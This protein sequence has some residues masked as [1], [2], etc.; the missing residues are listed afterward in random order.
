MEGVEAVCFPCILQAHTSLK[1]AIAKMRLLAKKRRACHTLVPK[2]ESHMILASIVHEPRAGTLLRH[3]LSFLLLGSKAEVVQ[4]CPEHGEATCRSQCAH[5]WW[6]WH[7]SGTSILMEQGDLNFTARLGNFKFDSVIRFEV[8]LWEWRYVAGALGLPGARE[9][10]SEAQWLNSK[11]QFSSCSV[12]GAWRKLSTKL[13]VCL[14]EGLSWQG[15][16]RVRAVLLCVN[17]YVEAWQ[18]IVTHLL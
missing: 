5:W 16:W 12:S 3:P 1:C 4:L 17:W 7:W 14:Q 6:G 10:Q 15:V 2:P 9:Q 18:G 11:L 8:Q 13:E